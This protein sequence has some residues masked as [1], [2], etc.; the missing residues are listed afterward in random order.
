MGQVAR[1]LAAPAAGRP[2]RWPPRP[3]A[4]R[5]APF[6]AG[7]RPFLAPITALVARPAAPD[8]P[9]RIFLV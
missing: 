9:H 1:P 6:L 2:G 3:L 5:A 7:R 4:G 8:G